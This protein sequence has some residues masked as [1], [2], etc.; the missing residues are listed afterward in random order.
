LVKGGYWKASILE[1]GEFGLL[2]EAVTPGFVYDDMTIAKPD[3]L[4]TQFPHLWD[5]IAP[6]IAAY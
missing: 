5:Q 2:S 1:K 4:Q 3:M 6:Y